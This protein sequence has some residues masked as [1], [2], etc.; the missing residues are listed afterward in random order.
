MARRRRRGAH[1]S[2]CGRRRAAC[3]PAPRAKA[4]CL[5]FGSRRSWGCSPQ[6][7]C[8]A[9]CPPRLV[10]ASQAGSPGWPPVRRRPRCLSPPAC[11][12]TSHPMLPADW[13]TLTRA[14]LIAG[15]AGLVA[16][17]FGRPVP[18]TALVTLSTVA[19]VLDAVDGQVARRTGTATP[20]GARH[21]R[22]GRRLPHPA[23]QHRRVPGL[24]RLGAGHRR[25]PLRAAA[26]GLADPV[27][28]RAVAAPVLAQGRGRGPG[29]RA[30]RRRIRSARAA[31][32]G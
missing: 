2:A 7:P 9:S 28:G 14:L 24:R 16:D 6:P 12:A 27:A 1:G 18:I 13:V 3:D 17:S 11:A 4:R 23:A 25:R 29:H 32:S 19:L 30:H 21:R 31:V 22:R 20:L 15:V 8:S 5:R 26:G 10:S